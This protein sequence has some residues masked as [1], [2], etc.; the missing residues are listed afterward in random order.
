MPSPKLSASSSFP[1]RG[2]VDHDATSDGASDFTF[3]SNSKKSL[4]QTSFRTNSNTSQDNAHLMSSAS[5]PP[6]DVN[7]LPSSVDEHSAPFSDQPNRHS[8]TA[9]YRTPP[10]ANLLW[11]S[12]A[13]EEDL[14][15]SSRTV[16]VSGV[17]EKQQLYDQT[18][19]PQQESWGS[20][21]FNAEPHFPASRIF[22]KPGGA[23]S[24]PGGRP[25][26]KRKKVFIPLIL[27]ALLIVLA[28]VF[29]PLGLLVFKKNDDNSG[30]NSS[31][32]NNG[33]LAGSSSDKGTPSWAKGTYL[34]ISTWMDTHDFNTTFTNATVGGLS[35][36]GLN[37]TWDNSAQA[38]KLVPPLEKPFPYGELPIRGVNLG[39]WLIVEPF[40]TPSYFN[41]TTPKKNTG[42]VDEWTLVEH[43]NSTGGMEEV[44]N[45]LE[46]HYMSFVTEDTFKE[47]SEAGL[48]HVRI[49]YGYWAVTTYPGDHFLPKVS[50]R[51]LL[52]AIEWA[53]KY[54]LRVNVDLHSVPG[55]QNGWNHSGRQGWPQWLNGTRGGIYGNESLELHKQLGAFFAQD[56]YKNLVTIY[57]LVNEPKMQTLNATV[58]IDWTKKAYDIVREKGYNG[59]I[60]FG[61]GFLGYA[62]W[63]GVFPESQFE[64]MT[65]DLHQY[66]IFNPDTLQMSHSAKLNFVCE[67]WGQMMQGSSNTTTGHGPT[68]VGEWSQADTDCTYFLNNVG[69]GSRWEGDFNPGYGTAAVLQP[70]CPDPTNCT[71]A[72]ANVLPSEYSAEYKTFL[73]M[74]TELQMDTFESY[75]AWG[76][77][78]WTWDTE[79]DHSAQWS[80]KKSREAGTIPKVAYER[81]YNCSSVS[82][83]DFVA[84]GLPESY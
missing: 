12:S 72:P 81:T 47:I 16:P 79:D 38:N 33:S 68:F 1:R 44:K 78:Y 63:K 32:S 55:G 39:G 43:L 73:R 41:Q 7:A 5:R 3:L 82:V 48:D 22:E 27:I 4:D 77:M 60:V 45:V 74:F 64:N 50:W 67:Q 84:A 80:Y 76:S 46:K 29:I 66:T 26:W 61:D 23:G 17:A 19:A 31:N 52:R 8:T 28:A 54:G 18:L 40:I 13:H 6:F 20:D 49:P 35:I 21:A 36:M 34:D 59:N 11:N 53:R 62:S 56:R 24:G 9:A 30:S 15:D 70:S 25:K 71:C 57:G 2:V 75:G 10:L 42:V 51:Y 65:L 69:V 58:V 37:S 83:P 14:T